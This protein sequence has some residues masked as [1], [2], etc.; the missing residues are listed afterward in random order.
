[1]VANSDK[2]ELK[3]ELQKHNTKY[4]VRKWFKNTFK[5]EHLF[6]A[7]TEICTIMVLNTV[8]VS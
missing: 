4:V 5:E 7:N 8:Q 3:N 2:A 1:M 6:K